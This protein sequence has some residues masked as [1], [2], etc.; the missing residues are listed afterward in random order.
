MVV[1]RVVTVAAARRGGQGIFQICHEPPH[2]LQGQM[3]TVSGT[4]REQKV[5]H[6]F[7][8]NQ[9][10]RVGRGQHAHVNIAQLWPKEGHTGNFSL[11]AQIQQEFQNARQHFCIATAG[12]HIGKVRAVLLGWQGIIMQQLDGR[13]HIPR[14]PKGLL[15]EPHGLI[16]FPSKRSM[17]RI[18]GSR[19]CLLGVFVHDFQEFRCTSNPTRFQP[20][21]INMKGP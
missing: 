10:I 1:A 12:S 8:T 2:Q 6:E 21:A 20:T 15:L 17:S 4:Y 19:R 16:I 18:H 9:G 5:L 7:H 11:I 3:H 14:Y 13:S